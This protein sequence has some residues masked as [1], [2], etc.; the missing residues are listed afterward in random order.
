MKAAAFVLSSLLTKLGHHV[1]TARHAAAALEA[2]VQRRPDVVISDIEMPDIDGY[3]LARR[4][5]R[6][7]EMD[8]VVLVALTGYGQE[9]DRQKAVEAGFDYHLVKPVSLDALQDLLA[10]LPPVEEIIPPTDATSDRW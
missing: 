5:R 9:Q 1:E 7:P 4:L 10:S 6:M 8:T 3:E 2:I